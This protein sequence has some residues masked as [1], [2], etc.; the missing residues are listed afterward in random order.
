MGKKHSL[1]NMTPFA[2]WNYLRSAM[3]RE[4]RASGVK[5]QKGQYT[6]LVRQIYHSTKDRPIN[7]VIGGLGKWLSTEVQ[8]QHPFIDPI[9]FYYI[10]HDLT[11]SDKIIPPNV[12]IDSTAIDG[13][14]Y[15]PGE[16]S[17]DPIFRPLVQNIDRWFN[18]INNSG[19]DR[20]PYFYLTQPSWNQGTKRWESVWIITTASGTTLEGFEWNPEEEQL[21][22]EKIVHDITTETKPILPTEPEPT[23]QKKYQPEVDKAKARKISN[24]D[25][26]KQISRLDKY[27]DKLL[28]KMERLHQLKLSEPLKLTTKEYNDT[29]KQI[30]D[31][32]HKLNN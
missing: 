30:G 25:L 31:L 13:K 19:D 15:Y 12:W 28:T 2:R 21:D 27:S 8:P 11:D 6:V 7:E 3:S 32:R 4:V 10:D 22:T 20:M 14:S 5:L 16:Y 17:Y 24:T 26:L 9:P 23:P 29:I 18:L 1:D